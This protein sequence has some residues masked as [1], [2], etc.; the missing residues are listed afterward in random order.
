VIADSQIGPRKFA[1]SVIGYRRCVI[2]LADPARFFEVNRDELKSILDR[3]IGS[4]QFVLGEMVSNFESEFS[5]Y[6]GSKYCVGVANGTDALEIA[7]R[8]LG[9][10]GKDV[11]LVANAGGYG[12]IACRAIGA[13]PRFVDIEPETLLISL[14]QI[15]EKVTASTAAIIVTHLFGLATDVR[16]IDAAVKE[17]LGYSV[18]IVEDCAQAHGAKVENTKAGA[19]GTIGCFSFYP[20][21]NLGALGDGGCITTNDSELNSRILQLRQYG[22]AE[23]YDQ[24]I[25]GGRN[26][27]LDELQAGFLTLFLPQ[28]DERNELRRSIVKKYY[29]SGATVVHGGFSE[30]ENYVAHLAVCLVDNR[31]EFLRRF[32]E[33]SV[34]TGIHYP[35]LDTDFSANRSFSDVS[36]PNSVYARSRV[37]TLPCFPELTVGE[38]DQVCRLISKSTEFFEYKK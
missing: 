6:V 10:Q 22:W 9:S 24:S 35:L 29:E 4:R 17:K 2:P 13:I 3:M 36:L 1:S 11:L 21:K 8:A 7:L 26:S 25:G 12:S 28:L 18:P 5:R 38:V 32:A 20:T 14:P 31:A 15:I 19:L 16:K 37:V 27:R 33:S 34:T 23:K 30:N